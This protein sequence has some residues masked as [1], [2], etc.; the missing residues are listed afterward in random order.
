MKLTLN[1]VL[2]MA[3]IVE[4]EAMYDDERPVIAG[5]YY[6]RLRKRMRLQADP[7]VQYAVSDLP[8]RLSRSDLK[9][10]SPYNT[11]EHYGLPPGPINNPGRK[12]ILAALY[13][14]KHQY[15]YFV[16]NYNGRHRFSRTYEEHQR[17]VREYRKAR[18]LASGR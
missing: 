7:T 9:I 12:S 10:D 17:H 3:S 4:G 18:A 13:P 8:R 14:A 6:N 15:L 5:V 1:E 11:Y 16:S 2:T